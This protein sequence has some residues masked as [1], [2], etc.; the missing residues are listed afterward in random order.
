MTHKGLELET[1]VALFINH[2]SHNMQIHFI[3]V[4]NQYLASLTLQWQ[5]RNEKKIPRAQKNTAMG[6]NQTPCDIT[7]DCDTLLNSCR[8]MATQLPAV[9]SAFSNVPCFSPLSNT[10]W[11]LHS[12]SI[13]RKL[14]PSG[15]YCKLSTEGLNM[16][17]SAD[18]LHF[19]PNYLCRAALLDSGTTNKDLK[20]TRYNVGP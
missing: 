2:S 4:F 17:F 16:P 1:W 14:Q 12:V 15:F 18:C 5:S 10:R 6:T 13:S 7:K 20:D 3:N 11:V 8:L 19:Y 9:Y